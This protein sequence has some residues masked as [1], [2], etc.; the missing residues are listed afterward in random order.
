MRPVYFMTG[1]PGFIATRL[2]RRLLVGEPDA[3]FELLVH[4]SQRARAERERAALGSAEQFALVE[5][6]ITQ[7]DLGLPTS[8]F[9][10]LQDEVTHVF[11]LAAVYDLAVPQQ[12]AH[13]VNVTGTRM[14]NAF[15]NSLT[16]LQRYVYFSTAYV[17]GDRAGRVLETELVKGQNFKN[18]YE[19][20]KY[21]AEVLVQELMQDVPITI[22]RPGVV[23]GDS[24]TG[25]TA[26]FDGPYF[27]MRF[28]EKFASLPIP[29]IGSG[30][31]LVNLVPIDYIVEATCYLAHAAA[32]AGK[33]YHLTDPQPYNAKQV[34]E[35]ICRELLGK[36]PVWTLPAGVVYAALSV[37]AFR[38]WVQV[39]RETL[40]YFVEQSVYD[41]AQAQRDLGAAGIHC[42]DLRSYMAQEVAFY[43][44]HRTD[45][46]KLI[47]VR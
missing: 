38:K 44:Q 45:R 29:Y 30:V 20:T 16:N 3:R 35:L 37:T 22:I 24:Q 8:K 4:P 23:M 21:E 31:A 18:Q 34:Y 26:K 10:E 39:E 1:F 25:E 32:G 43:K 6:D 33:V 36:P 11:H 2:I 19:S 7:P 17:S 9:A 5:G 46:E 41:T 14:V 42:P 40:A 28:L 15:V 13:E 27:I 12:L 47:A